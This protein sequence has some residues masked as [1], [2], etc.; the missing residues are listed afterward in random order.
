MP[1]EVGDSYHLLGLDLLQP[2]CQAGTVLPPGMCLDAALAPVPHKAQFCSVLSCRPT[3]PGPPAGRM[4]TYQNA[5]RESLELSFIWGKMRTA[6]QETAAQI[7]LRNCSKE[8]GDE[9]SVYLSFW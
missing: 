8:A 4:S 6:A 3:C 7:A 9:R 2:D 1:V 5:Q